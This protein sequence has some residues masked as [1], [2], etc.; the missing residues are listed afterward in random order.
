MEITMMFLLTMNVALSS[1]LLLTVD[2]DELLDI[3]LLVDSKIIN[4]IESCHVLLIIGVI[5]NV[6]LAVTILQY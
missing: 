6:C 1:L 3:I 4:L 2:L 5:A